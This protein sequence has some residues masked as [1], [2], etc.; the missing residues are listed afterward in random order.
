MIP[1]EPQDGDLTEEVVVGQLDILRRAIVTAREQSAHPP[2]WPP[3]GTPDIELA[4]WAR[5]LSDHLTVRLK[6][7][8]VSTPSGPVPFH[9]LTGDVEELRTSRATTPRE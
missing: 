7:F 1:A 4:R 9:D 8:P 5:A 6:T 3:G 2:H